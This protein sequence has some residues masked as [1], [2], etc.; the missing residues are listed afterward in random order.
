[1][2]ANSLSLR[3]LY[4]LGFLFA[5]FPNISCDRYQARHELKLNEYFSRIVQRVDR[6]WIG[7]DRFF[8]DNLLYN[9]HPEV[10]EWCAIALG[11]IASPRALPLLYR[12]AHSGY[13][14][15]RAAAAFS[16]GEILDRELPR[17]PPTPPD[18]QALASLHSLLSD[19]CVS[20][21]MRAIEALGKIGSHPDAAA[22]IQRLEKFT[23][24][25]GGSPAER[26]YAGFAITALA[27]L[28]DRSAEPMLTQ[29]AKA[30][31]PEI[32]WRA[33]QALGMLQQSPA[34]PVPASP[35]VQD[36]QPA[37]SLALLQ[38]MG[39]SSDASD[40]VP[41]ESFLTDSASYALAASRNNSTIAVVET[42]RGVLEIELF[43]EDA[44]LT[45]AN[46]VLTAQRGNYNFSRPE[47]WNQRKSGFVFDQIV[48]S[49]QIAG[50]V[51]G[52]QIGFGWSMNGEVSMR[53]FERGSIGL[54]TDRTD[55]TRRRL[56]IALAPLPYL[57]GID[58]C[59][60]RVLSGMPVA[61]RI[62]ASDK[63]LRIRIED[64]TS[65]LSHIR[66]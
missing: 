63:I 27:R 65:S 28:H 59:F 47:D 48:P 36:S 29:L 49:Q 55:P 66:Y 40:P 13:A 19:T 7:N 2:P 6:R 37:A 4:V 52:A 1:M 10:R 3:R 12:A 53:P 5:I 62:V 51:M 9:P 23:S 17:D 39:L 21:E 58:T 26:A 25:T 15:V 60:G 44:P 32:R 18:P 57:D 41:V 61:D 35:V 42:T 43:R 34:D 45:V 16:I 56:F 20:V 8:E 22:I 64:T 46:F 38:K 24:Q 11:R 33:N 54:S 31:D 30:P 14:A 50:A